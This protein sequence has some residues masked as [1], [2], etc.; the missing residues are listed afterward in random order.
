MPHFKVTPSPVYGPLHA[1]LWD[2][3]GHV[4][5]WRPHG[6]RDWLLLYTDAGEGLVRHG[7]AEFRTKPGDVIL[8]LPGTAQDYGQHEPS[9]RWRHVWAHWVPRAEVRGW[10]NWREIS[11]GL[12]HLHLPRELRAPVLRELAMM[13]ST[14]RA[15]PARGE[16]LALN[17]LER[18][19]LYCQRANPRPGGAGWHPRI[20]QAADF[21]GQNLRDAHRLESLARRFG[22]SRSRFAALF[23]R[24]MGQPPLRYLETLQLAQ[25]R[26]LLSYTNQTLAQIAE[27]VGYSSAFHFSL[28]F[29]RHFGKSPR[30]FRTGPKRRKVSRGGLQRAE[31]V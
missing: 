28:R 7:T 17:A 20:Q 9:G 16:V 23:R 15:E 29:K 11:P 27:Q 14:L 31:E 24:Q 10:L 19:L 18:A 6:T 22:F 5:G 13:A 2:T 1:A 26:Q 25:G 8:Y 12:R 3:R 21:L 4:H 30:E